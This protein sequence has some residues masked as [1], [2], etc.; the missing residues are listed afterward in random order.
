MFKIMFLSV[1]RLTIKEVKNYKQD[2]ILS[3]GVTSMHSFSQ[4]RRTPGIF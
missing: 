1:L 2:V 4:W 3:E